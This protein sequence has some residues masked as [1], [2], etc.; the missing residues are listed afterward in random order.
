[1]QKSHISLLFIYLYFNNENYIKNEFTHN[2][3]VFI[4]E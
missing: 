3:N 4:I 2:E 1:M